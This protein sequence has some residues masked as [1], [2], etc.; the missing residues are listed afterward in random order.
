MAVCSFKFVDGRWVLEP[1]SPI[2][3]AGCSVNLDFSVPPGTIVTV[4]CSTGILISI[5]LSGQIEPSGGTII[6]LK[7]AA[8]GQWVDSNGDVWNGRIGNLGAV[9]LKGTAGAKIELEATPG[10]SLEYKL[11]GLVW[12]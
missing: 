1:P 2:T 5:K 12:P 10:T 3:P 7:A 11:V 9:S 8:D 4:D 6:K